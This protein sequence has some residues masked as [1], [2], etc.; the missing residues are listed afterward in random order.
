MRGAALACALLVACSTPPPAPPASDARAPRAGLRELRRVDVP[1]ASSYVGTAPA[2][3]TAL[4]A[5][6]GQVTWLDASARSVR[7]APYGGAHRLRE[8]PGGVLLAE[9][10]LVDAATGARRVS[11]ETTLGAAVAADATTDGTLAIIA[12]RDQPSRCCRGEVAPADERAGVA[13]LTLGAGAAQVVA[14]LPG[15]VEAVAAGRDHLA[16]ATPRELRIWARAALATPQH[17]PLTPGDVRAVLWVGAADD[18]VVVLRR[19]GATRAIVQAFASATGFAAA[20]P[21]TIDAGVEAMVARPGQ[22][23][24]VLLTT[25]D[26]RHLTLDGAELARRALDGV[27]LGLAVLAD[28]A[29]AVVLLARPDG[30]RQLV[31]L[32]L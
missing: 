7:A 31:W 4:V 16:T 11:L 3:T 13:L 18:A 30:A 21:W 19:D 14:E 24:L 17:V 25:D 12:G 29:S 27:P 20:A 2:G 22:A 26:V 9:P 28:G 10:H 1:A 23:E 5:D 8:L 15:D 6:A 32:A